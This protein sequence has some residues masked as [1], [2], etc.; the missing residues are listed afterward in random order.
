MSPQ[1]TD[2]I[3]ALEEALESL[4]ETFFKN[5]TILVT[6]GSDSQQKEKIHREYA[7]LYLLKKNQKCQTK[8][9]SKSPIGLTL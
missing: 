6:S 2:P 5:S 8:L 7:E 3:R 4:R 9:Q 1:Y